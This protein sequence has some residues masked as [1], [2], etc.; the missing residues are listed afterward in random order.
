MSSF[1]PFLFSLLLAVCVFGVSG[2]SESESHSSLNLTLWSDMASSSSS[3]SSTA[4]AAAVA[5]ST[6]TESSDVDPDINTQPASIHYVAFISQWVSIPGSVFIIFYIVKHRNIIWRKNPGHR[7]PLYISVADVGFTTT[8]FIDHV[9]VLSTGKYPPHSAC[10]FFAWIFHFMSFSTVMTVM[11]VSLYCCYTVVYLKRPDLGRYDWKLIAFSFG[12]PFLFSLVPFTTRSYGHDAAWCWIDQSLPQSHLAYIIIPYLFF[13]CLNIMV[14]MIIFWKLATTSKSTKTNM[15]KR[16]V[17]FVLAYI[18]QFTPIVVFSIQVYKGVDVPYN[19]VLFVVFNTNLG[20]F[21]NV[22]VYGFGI[23]N[24]GKEAA[25][26]K[27]AQSKATSVS[28]DGHPT[29]SPTVASQTAPAVRK[30]SLSSHTT[31]HTANTQS[32]TNKP[33]AASMVVS[34]ALYAPQQPS[35]AIRKAKLDD[36]HKLSTVSSTNDATATATCSTT[37][38]ARG[39]GSSTSTS[40]GDDHQKNRPSTSNLELT[41]VGSTQVHHSPTSQHQYHHQLQQQPISQA[42]PPSLSLSLSGMTVP[43]QTRPSDV[44]IQI[45]LLPAN[46]HPHRSHPH[47]H[48]QPQSQSPFH[49]PSLATSSSINGIRSPPRSSRKVRIHLPSESTDAST[50]SAAAAV[51]LHQLPSST[52]NTPA[53]VPVPVPVHASTTPS[54]Y[55]MPTSPTPSR[56]WELIFSK[57][58]V[59]IEMPSK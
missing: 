45:S 14:L 5:P 50:S 12:I 22:I 54:T 29:R 55:P 48:S 6:V 41:L 24:I 37:S 40:S 58:D 57:S 27:L 46:N 10:Q 1:L 35:A 38:T 7:F 51:W 47:P 13:L 17:L 11:C 16:S 20:G 15:V 2:D 9:I 19:T 43:Q 59:I 42:V 52:I 28:A 26:E 18:F 30:P 33:R 4:A 34:K 25:A 32:N 44:H 21:L 49:S 31:V 39:S 53:P 56:V 8:H 23:L 36:T 3:S